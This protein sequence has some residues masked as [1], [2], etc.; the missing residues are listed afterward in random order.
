MTKE[1]VLQKVTDYCNEKSYTSAT[2]TDAFKDKFA[3][4]FQKA[5]PDGDINDENVLKSLK[6]A[7]NTAFSS[8]SELATVKATEFTSKEND[9]KSQIAELKKKI[10]ATPKVEPTIPQEV[11]DQLNELKAFK[12]AKSKQEKLAN[13]MTL[14]KAEIRQDL[15][16]SFDTF[17]SEYEVK[18]DKE[19]KEQANALVKKFQEIFKDSIGDIKP[20]APQVSQKRDEEALAAIPKVKV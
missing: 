1:E 13:I 8:A 2:L 16:K 11:Q 7:L 5:D 9:L 15:H 17:A 14:A 3:D 4:H 10:P 6:F 18:L 12:D 19:D 20:L